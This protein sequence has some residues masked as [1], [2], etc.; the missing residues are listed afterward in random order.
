MNRLLVA[1]LLT[2]LFAS[3]SIGE[4]WSA[5]RGP[6]GDGITTDPAPTKWSPTENIAWR[7]KI[8]GAG[9]S[10]PILWK[11]HL[12]VTT[13]LPDDLSR[14][15]LALDRRSGKI[16]WDTAVHHG[17]PGQAHRQN[18]PASSTPT[19]D[20]THVYA[21]FV[22]DASIQVVA[23]DF[24]GNFVWKKRLAG[25]NS[26]HGFAASPVLTKHGLVVN[27]QQDGEGAF[28]ACL[29]PKNGDEIWRYTPIINLRSFSTPLL[30]GHESQSQLILCG[31][32][33]T[34][35]IDPANGQLIWSAE[36]PSQ[37]FVCTPSV[38]HG[39][40]FSF[41]GSPEKKA[42]AVRLGGQGDI[43]A[44]HV[45]WR[46]DRGMPY[47]PSPLLVGDYL[48]IVNDAGIY[49]C[50]EPGSG[51]TLKTARKFGN[52]YSSPI[53]A[54]DYLYFFEDSGACT[55]IEN[56]PEFKEVAKNEL[57]VLVQTTPAV[58]PGALYVRGEGELIC[59]G[60]P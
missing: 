60:S 2:T 45:A 41:G 16:L 11:D 14:R 35:G 50:L 22:D 15:V 7:T 3:D 20:G 39:H 6:R 24:T 23:V 19:T 37:K 26:Q 34:V 49:T 8:P 48:H 33:Q 28:V 32:T 55:V 40:V 30:I 36:G 47:V 46:S 43:L 31:S 29:S 44:S 17:P 53:A 5:W 51:K 38:G 18:T 59:V 58:S 9:N 4:E 13:S 54:G 27:G 12:F 21:V 57:G 56:G 10:S 1:L 25:F 42:F 52:V